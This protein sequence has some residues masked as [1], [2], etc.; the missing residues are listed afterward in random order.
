MFA[1]RDSDGGDDGRKQE[2][3]L[4]FPIDHSSGRRD[5]KVLVL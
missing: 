1:N 2:D 3:E 5:E 4:K